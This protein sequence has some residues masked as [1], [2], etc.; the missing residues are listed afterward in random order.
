MRQVQNQGSMPA[1]LKA[2]TCSS[3]N[4][5]LTLLSLHAKRASANVPTENSVHAFKP[6]KCSAKLLVKY[7][8]HPRTFERI[9]SNGWSHKY[10]PPSRVRPSQEGF[11]AAYQCR[12]IT[13]QVCCSFTE[14]MR[15]Y[16]GTTVRSKSLKAVSITWTYSFLPLS[17]N[18]E[19]RKSRALASSHAKTWDSVAKAFLGSP[20]SMA[21]MWA[22]SFMRL[23]PTTADCARSSRPSNHLI[24]APATQSPASESATLRSPMFDFSFQN[25]GL[26][27]Q[28]PLYV[29]SEDPPGNACKSN[30]TVRL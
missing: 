24:N 21:A 27:G 5:R 4:M 22:G 12:S 10:P 15:L 14:K 8:T 26:A 29:P 2:L 1:A 17:G 19:D 6:W 30:R 23:T 20:A 28:T 7:S 3:K 13:A 25:A 18:A 11:H 9:S 16:H